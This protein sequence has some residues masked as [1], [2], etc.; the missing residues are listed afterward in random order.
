[1]SASISDLI[2]VMQPYAHALVD[3]GGRAGVQPRVTSTLRTHAQQ[4]RLY[5]AFLRGE[6]AYP[7]APPGFSAHEY[8]FAFDM[9]AAT[10]E[11]LHDL[12][13]VWR[14]AG[15]VW[16]PA[17]EVHFEFPGFVPPP[18]PEDIPLPELVKVC[19]TLSSFTGFGA[20][21]IA[22]SVAQWI[23]PVSSS[24]DSLERRVQAF[25]QGPC[26]SLYKS[27]RY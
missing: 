2:Q 23:A 21:Q 12:G 22:E 15:G 8:G 18:A 9:V 11:D 10:R 13:S 20:I 4:Q 6:N 24:P 5:A 17:D 7:V 14:D 16:S 27:L 1:M 19:D 3:L 25:I 26:S